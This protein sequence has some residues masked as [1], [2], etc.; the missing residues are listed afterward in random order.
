MIVIGLLE[1]QLKINDFER[2]PLGA[3]KA[4]V[5]VLRNKH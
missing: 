1:R 5:P 2:Q 3:A 4:E